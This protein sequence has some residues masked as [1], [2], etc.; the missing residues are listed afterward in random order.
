MKTHGYVHTGLDLTCSDTFLSSNSIMFTRDDDVLDVFAGVVGDA[1][2]HLDGLTMVVKL[3]AAP[4]VREERSVCYLFIYSQWMGLFSLFPNS[5][6]FYKQL[7][8]TFKWSQRKK[9][10]VQ[11]Y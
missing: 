2:V 10:Q 7:I 1:E 4:R 11:S 8:R 3:E 6:M 9:P 5:K